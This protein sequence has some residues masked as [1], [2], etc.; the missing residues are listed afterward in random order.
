LKGREAAL[1]S[2]K[3]KS[4]LPK[5]VN[6]QRRAGFLSNL[7]DLVTLHFHN[8]VFGSQSRPSQT[9]IAGF[10]NLCRHYTVYSTVSTSLCI[11]PNKGISRY[12]A[13]CA[14]L[15]YYFAVCSARWLCSLHMLYCSAQGAHECSTYLRPCHQGLQRH[16]DGKL[17]SMSFL[18]SHAHECCSENNSLSKFRN[19]TT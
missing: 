3:S 11:T 8:G 5:V 4:P 16:C 15:P 1:A 7:T 9:H 14:M 12:L 17:M 13:S 6:Y 19:V 18:G 2:P 10:C